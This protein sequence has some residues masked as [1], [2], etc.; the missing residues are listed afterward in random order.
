VDA[1][2]AGGTEV[3]G[4]RTP[5]RRRRVLAGIALVLACLT[6]LVTTVAVW[7]HQVAFNTDRFTSLVENVI[8]EPAV[9][10][11]LS[12]KVSAQVITALNVQGRI[13]Q[14]LPDALKPLAASITL[15]VQEAIANRLQQALDNPRIQQALVRTISVA[16][17]KVMNLLRDQSDAVQVVNGYVVIDVWPVV[18]AALAELQSMGI[19][20][21]DIQLPDL[22][23]ADIGAKLG[24][25]L[26]SA[27]GVTL[28]ADFGTVQLMP[29]DR[30]LTARTVVRAFDIVV[31]LLIVLSVV[32]VALALWLSTNR[33][34]MVIY[35]AL[36]VIIAFLLA[37]L[38]TNTITGAVVGGIAD[39]GLAGAVRTVVDATVANLR[40]LTAIILVATGIVAVAAYLWGRPR[41]LTS[42]ASAASATAGQAGSAAAGAGSAGMGAVAASRP[43]RETLE[44]SVR[45]NRSMIERY[46]L[47]AIVFVVAWL[48]LGLTIALVG[49]VLVIAFELLLRA[50]APTQEEA[51]SVATGIAPSPAMAGGL[52][53]PTPIVEPLVPSADVASSDASTPEPTPEPAPEAP[54]APP[55]RTRARPTK[56]PPTTTK[57][58]P[59]S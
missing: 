51:V 39:Q 58:P 22:S 4:A 33:R 46:G 20:P 17:E 15:T 23:D 36:G 31:I 11:P 18:D 47:A 37:R 41:W 29:A 42:A 34:M 54:P 19:I 9:T 10:D 35:L 44:T 7:A 3:S 28:P 48:A 57:K 45:E 12:A 56:K 40:Q 8:D 16:H 5:R 53:M 14:R 2:V 32:L 49:A 52:P 1:T 27:L 30:L 25:R 59:P 43:S 21:A 50:V 24:P 6:I 55:K 26:E 13:E 38:S